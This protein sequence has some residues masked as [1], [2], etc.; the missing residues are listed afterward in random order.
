MGLM[1]FAGVE[2]DGYP[3]GLEP[4]ELAGSISLLQNMAGSLSATARLVEYV[5]GQ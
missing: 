3:R 4:K 2:D 1:C 5:P